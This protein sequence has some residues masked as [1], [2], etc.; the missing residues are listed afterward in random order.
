M[1][2]ELPPTGHSL[3]ATEPA[4]MDGTG[5][6]LLRDFRLRS[7]QVISGWLQG[8]GVPPG[9]TLDSDLSEAVRQVNARIGDRPWMAT[10]W[11]YPQRL[12][13]ERLPA[14]CTADEILMLRLALASSFLSLKMSGD[15]LRSFGAM[16]IDRQIL[17][18][19]ASLR[20]TTSG[21]LGFQI[22]GRSSET[23][24]DDLRVLIAELRQL[25]PLHERLAKNL[26]SWLKATDLWKTEISAAQVVDLYGA[27]HPRHD[28]RCGILEAMEDIRRTFP[29]YEQG[30][31]LRE[32]DSGNQFLRGQ[33]KVNDLEARMAFVERAEL[34]AEGP[35][36]R[37]KKAE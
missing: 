35:K 25:Q 16:N 14:P 29:H 18:L 30:F 1:S 32:F 33:S 24:A 34:S 9:R 23:Y 6:K 11:G 5:M 3:G 37:G 27:Q 19:E 21:E 8:A 20:R 22:H 36:P 4:R 28:P 17:D 12:R 31:S 10:F 7:I 26:K 2:P 15:D 13:S